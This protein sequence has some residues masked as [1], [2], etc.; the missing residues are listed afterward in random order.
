[1]LGLDLLRSIQASAIH[2]LH[3]LNAISFRVARLGIYAGTCFREMHVLR[4]RF[5]IALRCLHSALTERTAR[6][7]LSIL[8]Q[9]YINP[10]SF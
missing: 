6:N 8:P 4:A 9:F 5:Y 3:A 10:M 1:M 2:Y 7:Q